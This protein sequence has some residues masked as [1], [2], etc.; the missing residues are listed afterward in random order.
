MRR[1]NTI[2]HIKDIHSQGYQGNNIGI[3]VLDTGIC[4]HP[5]FITFENRIAAFKDFV[6]YKN[7][8]YDD[9][10]H[11]SHVSGIIA[12]NGYASNGTYC[13]VAP[14]AHII[15]LKVLD[16]NGR[17]NV[18]NVL[19]ALKWLLENYHFY[20]I[21]IVNISVGSTS[22]PPDQ[23]DSL[24]VHAVNMLW[25]E[26]LVVVA[27]AG[28]GGP[29]PQSIG[30]PGISRKIIT[31]GACDDEISYDNNSYSQNK[32][33]SG[34][35]PTLSC[36]KKPD[37]VAPG[38]HIISCNNVFPNDLFSYSKLSAHYP[39]QQIYHRNPTQ[40]YAYTYENGKKIRENLCSG[41]YTVK[42]GTS[43]ATPIVSGAIALLLSKYP[44]LSNKDI[45]IRLKNTSMDLGLSHS[46]QGWGLLNIK[47]LCL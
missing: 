42:S 5:D 43:M 2:L 27:A 47:K 1:S 19:N 46:R 41:F 3:A 25:D 30:T 15:S 45:K 39:L 13:G 29:M 31:V 28:N 22:Y 34:R 14:K 24:L 6:N 11:G 16:K 12:G 23:E 7:Y 36:I 35:G 37:I 32:N 38:N 18:K 26:G 10:S 9:N 44:N 17:G 4:E 8:V 20:H 40:N 33:Y 21:K